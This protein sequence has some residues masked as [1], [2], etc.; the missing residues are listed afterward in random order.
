MAGSVV[1]QDGGLVHVFA[2]PGAEDVSVVEFDTFCFDTSPLTLPHSSFQTAAT[3]IIMK[4]WGTLRHTS[5]K[6]IILSYS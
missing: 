4:L 2:T 1:N 3:R 6:Y 5:S